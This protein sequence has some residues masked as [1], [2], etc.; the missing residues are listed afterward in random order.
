MCRTCF[1]ADITGK[2][3]LLCSRDAVHIPSHGGDYTYL[4]IQGRQS[5][6]SSGYSGIQP[7][8]P[9]LTIG[10]RVSVFVLSF[11]LSFHIDIPTDIFHIS[12]CKL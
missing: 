9:S 8:P 6:D 7:W 10:K 12:L 11:V 4:A 3:K 2:A 5:D 1:D